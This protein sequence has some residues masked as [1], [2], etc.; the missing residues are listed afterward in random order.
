MTVRLKS[1]KASLPAS[2]AGKE[3]LTAFGPRACE[4]R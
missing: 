4:W 2:Y 1:V 3:A